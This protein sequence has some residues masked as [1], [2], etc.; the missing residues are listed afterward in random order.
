MELL[1]RLADHAI[2]RHHA[3][4]A[5]AE[6]PYLA[7][8]EA[9]AA[10]QAA[11]L[12]RWMLIG[13]VHGVMNTDNMT[14]SGETIDYGPCAF[15]DAYDP[16]TVYS[17]IDHGGR[18]AFGNQPGIAEWNLA[19]LAETLLPLIDDDQDKAVELAV[20]SLK[21]SPRSTRTP[22]S[23]V[24]RPSWGCPKAWTTCSSPN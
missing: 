14:I 18:Y 12:A 10:A 8:F 7:L 9:V 23:S 21:A 3:S 24:C 4:A 2:N 20:E 22:G 6:R 17:S 13:F 5:Q 16:A 19:R 11:L 1:R 15:V